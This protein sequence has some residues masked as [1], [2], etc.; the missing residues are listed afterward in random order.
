MH[1]NI[2][3]YS[4]IGILQYFSLISNFR[5]IENQTSELGQSV[6]L[7][8]SDLNMMIFT[9][10]KMTNEIQDI[11]LVIRYFYCLFN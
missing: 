8:N 6:G 7:P 4:I 2:L 5:N 9:V 11:L 10:Q 1:A 3:N